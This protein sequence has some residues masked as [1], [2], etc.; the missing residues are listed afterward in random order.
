MKLVQ[1]TFKQQPC[2]YYSTVLF[3]LHPHHDPSLPSVSVLLPVATIINY[4]K[5]HGLKQHKCII[6]YFWTLEV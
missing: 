3:D 5:L 6:L 2:S 4:H 1:Q